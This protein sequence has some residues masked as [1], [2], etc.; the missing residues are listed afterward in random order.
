M[1]EATLYERPSANETLGLNLAEDLLRDPQTALL[2]SALRKLTDHEPA[3]WDFSAIGQN[4]NSFAYFQYPAMMVPRM[5]GDIIN[6]I[7]TVVPIG[8]CIDPFVGSGTTLV[9]ALKRGI[10]PI[11]FDVNPMALL[12]CQVK[13]TPFDVKAV[14]AAFETVLE[15][16]ASD[17]SVDIVLNYENR[18]KW[19]SK[20]ALIELSRLHR[21]I[22]R[23]EKLS[24]RKVLWVA[25]AEAVRISCNSRTST[26]KLHIRSQDDIKRREPDLPT[27]IQDA[28]M[29]VLRLYKK[30][31]KELEEAGLVTG[32]KFS[33]EAVVALHDV[34]EPL[35][36]G[37]A[38]LLISSPPY[39][40]NHTTITYG[41]H[42]FLPLKWI[43]ANDIAE[44]V[45][46][47]V[48]NTHTIDSH[49]IGGLLTGVL[50]KGPAV[51]A[52]SV[53]LDEFLK[54]DRLNDHARKRVIA[55]FHDL[56]LA[57]ANAIGMLGPK[58]PI[59]LTLGNRN[60]AGVRVPTDVIVRE[61]LEWNGCSFVDTHNRVIPTKRMAHRNKTATTMLTETLLVMRARA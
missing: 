36:V 32:G 45:E 7:R 12:L 41:Q 46:L 51:R 40:D 55:F 15:A 3:Y 53:I 54:G 2:K 58:A 22:C 35:M 8:T 19:F 4:E 34:R 56:E 20:T 28:I 50:A 42:S 52:K 27:R 16:A 30:N 11:G 26:Y 29:R 14:E 6:A 5:Q 25:F 44:G 13:T 9:E 23:I 60:V 47:A 38:D 33:T 48:S 43:P 1:Q 21:A 18:D 10:Q 49:S 31:A 59:V 37:K 39:G 57:L 24:E 17:Q 61:L